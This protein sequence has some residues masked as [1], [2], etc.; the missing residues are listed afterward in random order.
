MRHSSI[1]SAL[2]L[3]AFSGLA[4]AQPLAITGLKKPQYGNPRWVNLIP[5]SYGDNTVINCD[6]NTLNG[7]TV[8]TVTKGIELGIPLSALGNPT[9]TIRACIF[10]NNQDGGYVSNQFSGTPLV[11]LAGELAQPANFGETRAVNL[12]TDA[13]AAGNQFFTINLNTT[14]TAPTIDGTRETTGWSTRSQQSARTGFGNSNSGTTDYANGSELDG[15]YTRVAGG[16]LYFFLTG[17]LESNHNTMEIFIDT[18]SAQGQNRLRG[19]NPAVGGDGLH[20]TRMGDDGSNNGFTFDA[21]FNA[22]YWVGLNC[23]DAPFAL[24]VDYAQ[25]SNNDGSGGGVGYYCGSSGAASNGVL[26][27][28]AVGAP[29]IVATIDNSNIAGV[30]DFCPPPAGNPDVSNGSELDAVYSYVDKVNKR[31]YVIA[32]G[33]VKTDYTSLNFFIDAG[34]FA[35]PGGIEHGQNQLRNDNSTFDFGSINNMGGIGSGTNPGLKFDSDFSPTYFLGY[36]NGGNVDNYSHSTVLRTN[37]RAT[38]CTAVMDYG[39]FDGGPKLVAGAN[40]ELYDVIK[41]NG[42]QGYPG[43]TTE[44]FVGIQEQ[45]GTR[46]E[47]EGNFAPYAGYKFMSEY[48]GDPCNSVPGN[49]SAAK[50]SAGIILMRM[51]Q[52]NLAGVTSANGGAPFTEDDVIAVQSGC[53]FSIDLAELGYDGVS[54][55]KLAGFL[56][57]GDRGSISN[58]VIGDLPASYGAAPGTNVGTTNQTDFNTIAGKQ[59]ITVFQ[60]CPWDLNHDTMVDD[61]DFVTFVSAYNDLIAPYRWATADFNG[62]GLV[63]DTDFVLF[64]SAYNDLLCP[65]PL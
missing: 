12:A 21:G 62:D 2:M 4:I 34:G 37:G 19:D 30:P 20:L 7:A 41:Y 48:V 57:G 23:G 9:G 49:P 56:G 14:S 25:L 39:M 44:P 1:A 24:Y 36:K 28:G 64:A 45:D 35:T 6:K 61:S 32:T 42:L 31:L 43:G 26:T 50:P 54:D 55:I 11:G 13:R 65:E 52:S 17:N 27:G 8:N 38:I 29:A 16:V 46:T 53:E 63:D 60:S 3:A 51:N 58:Q 18:G 15:V 40:G 10:I 5:T 47:L 22:S 33:N 59:W